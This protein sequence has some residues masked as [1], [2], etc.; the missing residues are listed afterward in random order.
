[1]QTPNDQGPTKSSSVEGNCLSVHDGMIHR[2]EKPEIYFD[3]TWNKNSGILDASLK[4][5]EFQGV[6]LWGSPG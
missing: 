2:Y 6:V 1:M 4:T 3:V 5:T